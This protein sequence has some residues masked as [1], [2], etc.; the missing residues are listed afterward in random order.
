MVHCKLYNEVNKM[1]TTTDLTV[2]VMRTAV[3]ACSAIS[4]VEPLPRST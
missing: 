2:C 4:N 1:A 3:K